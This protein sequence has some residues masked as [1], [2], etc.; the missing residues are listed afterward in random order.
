[1]V[2]VDVETDPLPEGPWDLIVTVHYLWRPLFAVF[3]RM[4][5]PGGILVVLHPTES[6]LQR[7]SKPPARFLLGDGEL[8]RLVEDLEMLHY[9]EGWLA[10]GRH[11]V[12]LMARRPPSAPIPDPD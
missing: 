12:L 5:R 10:E 6:N 9:E 8:P 11:E 1:M 2:S 3:S 4:L 7:H